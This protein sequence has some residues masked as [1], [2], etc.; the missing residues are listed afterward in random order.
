[1]YVYAYNLPHQWSY[2]N[3]SKPLNVF[4][5]TKTKK[6]YT[7]KDVPSHF[8]W[9]GFFSHCL[10][11]FPLKIIRNGQ[12]LMH[13]A[14]SCPFFPQCLFPFFVISL[15]YR[16]CTAWPSFVNVLYHIFHLIGFRFYYISVAF[17]IPVTCILCCVATNSEIVVVVVVIVV[18][19]IFQNNNKNNNNHHNDT[20]WRHRSPVRTCWVN[21]IS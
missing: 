2:A 3:T 8:C 4:P 18:T 7:Y 6:E 16:S 20:N 21:T 10:D 15:S 5:K 13:L 12:I 17:T 14:L 11:K 19:T 9:H 1:M